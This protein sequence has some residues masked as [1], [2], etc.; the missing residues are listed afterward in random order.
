M[1]IKSFFKQKENISQINTE[2]QK[3]RNSKGKNKYMYIYINK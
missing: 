3:E 1:L 2:M